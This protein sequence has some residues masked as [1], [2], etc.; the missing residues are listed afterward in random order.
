MEQN[1]RFCGSGHQKGRTAGSEEALSRGGQG[2]KCPSNEE[3]LEDIVGKRQQYTAHVAEDENLPQEV[4]DF[5]ELHIIKGFERI[6]MEKVIRVGEGF[7]GDDNS[8]HPTPFSLSRIPSGKAYSQSL[9]SVPERTTQVESVAHEDYG[10]P[11]AVMS[12]CQHRTW[13]NV[14]RVRAAAAASVAPVRGR[15]SVRLSCSGSLLKFQCQGPAW[16]ANKGTLCVWSQGDRQAS[17][18]VK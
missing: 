12:R 6:M 1:N 15:I 14:G 17:E 4:E 2:Y 7:R 9:H 13:V 3:S 5:K 8:P 11:Q 18:P 16:F 10:H